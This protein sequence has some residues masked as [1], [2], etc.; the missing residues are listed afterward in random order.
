MKSIVTL[1]SMQI[2]L[3]EVLCQHSDLLLGEL[4]NKQAIPRPALHSDNVILCKVPLNRKLRPP[5]LYSH[6]VMSAPPLPCLQS[7][8]LSHP[9]WGPLNSSRSLSLAVLQFNY[10]IFSLKTLSRKSLAPFSLSLLT[11]GFLSSFSAVCFPVF[12]LCVL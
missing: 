12:S 7:L 3:L 8:F 4:A 1:L 11:W 6:D 10:F 2:M 5:P 9:P